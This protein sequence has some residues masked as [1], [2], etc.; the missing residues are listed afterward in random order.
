MEDQIDAPEAEQGKR[1]VPLC[2]DLKKQAGRFVYLG[3]QRPSNHG[4]K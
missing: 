1:S 2:P 3:A 4:E